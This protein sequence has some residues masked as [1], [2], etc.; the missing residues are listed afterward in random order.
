M[1]RPRSLQARLAIWIG[2]LVTLLWIGAASV[3]ATLLRHE[4]D[5]VFDSALQET[6]Q[7]IL[8]L[9]VFEVV[10]RE[11]E[12]VTQRLA[13]IREHEEF[14]TYV[15]RDA[16]GRILLHSHAADPAAFPPYGGTGFRQD[17]THRFYSDAALRGSVTI[18]VAEPLTHR[19]TVA[20][21]MQLGLGLPLLAVIP[22]SLAGIVLAVRRSFGPLRR[23]RDALS[24]RG[25]H[26]QSPLAHGE[27]PSELV[28]V[29]GALNSLL[30]RLTAAF[31]AE[32]SFAA[33][34][35]HE[36]RTPLAGA[37]AQAQRLQSETGDAHVV[38][39][40]A[41]IEATLKRLTGLSERLM[42]LA[43][44]EGGRLNAERP[45]DLRPV[46]ELVVE[47]IRRMTHEDRI[48][49]SLPDQPVM[50]DL[51][52]DAFGILCRN[53]IE[54]A[55]RHGRTGTGIAVSLSAGGQL[56]VH[57]DSDVIAPEALARLT[58]RFERATGAGEGSGLG[59]AIAQ[60]IAERAGGS[61]VLRSPIPGQAAGF[62]A[63]VSLPVA[64][65][66]A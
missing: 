17:D 45:G 29:V 21:E 12:G 18:T 61:L 55:L 42:Q 16:K 1:I 33:S 37:I 63:E 19:Q 50:S 52:A 35:A 25:A 46:L 44:A 49:L 53:L 40:A 20:R 47:D 41:E 5:E 22:L 43:R 30:E 2:L 27:L 23:L 56:R 48:A 66:P 11:D 6:A 26:D 9:A 34:A 31:E 15:V 58:H 10:G 14:F 13:A 38:Q 51:D 7:R 3:T 24:S 54:N 36:L 65:T 28:P 64:A 57:N 8:P 32:R 60:T 62:E 59:L 4:M 39:R